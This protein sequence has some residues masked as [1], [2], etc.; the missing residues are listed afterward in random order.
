MPS[1]NLISSLNKSQLS[2]CWNVNLVYFFKSGSQIMS[3]THQL[4]H[5]W[6][7]SSQCISEANDLHQE[8]PPSF[9]VSTHTEILIV[10]RALFWNIVTSYR[11]N[12]ERH[13]NIIGVSDSHQQNISNSRFRP[14]RIL[15]IKRTGNAV[16][17]NKV[18]SL[19]CHILCD[20]HGF[21][22]FSEITCP[23]IDWL[24]P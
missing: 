11:D 21:D 19:E 1:I 4:T 2:I 22:G 12:L 20:L 5:F 18:Q 23:I 14:M 8:M 9:S 10:I 24:P 13:L 6:P 16:Q 3:T 15:T 17:R 7:I